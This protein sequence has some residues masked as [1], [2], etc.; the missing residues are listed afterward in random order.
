VSE[1][2]AGPTNSLVDVA[3]LR[4]GHASRSEAGWLTGTTVILAE[5]EGAVAGVD[6]RGGGPGTRETDLLQPRNLVERVHAVVLSG[7]S[8]FGLASADGVVQ[9]LADDGIG[10]PVGTE[11]GE[12]VPIVPAAII[13]DLGRGGAFRSHPG[14]DLGREAY[15]EARGQQGAQAVRQGCVGAGTGAVAGG[16]KGG[17]GSASAGIP[18]GWTV[19][20][21]AVANPGGSAVDPSSGRLWSA[22]CGLPGEFDQVVRRARPAIS[23]A[24]LRG[25]FNTT[26]GVVA[27]DAPLTK[28]QCQKLAEAAQDGLA[29]AIRPAHTMF[30]G[31][32][33]FGLSTAP[34]GSATGPAELNELLAVAA[35]CFARAVGRGLLAAVTTETVAGRWES[36]ADVYLKEDPDGPGPG[37]T[38][39]AGE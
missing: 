27:T 7:G 5:G 38:A 31:D 17:L 4:V 20:A 28:A 12:V 30:D 8:A 26:I 24:T 13:F 39:S 10:L 22:E 32:T 15:L 37:A 19:A 36:Y 23:R 16:L 29:R 34:P 6:V 9:A 25:S 35:D 11:P 14:P 33:I 1:P 3:R 18:G 2:I 21:L